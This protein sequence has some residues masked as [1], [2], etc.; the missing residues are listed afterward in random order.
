MT[1]GILTSGTLTS[2][3]LMSGTLKFGHLREWNGKRK[4]VLLLAAPAFTSGSFALKSGSFTS[5]TFRGGEEIPQGTQLTACLQGRRVQALSSHL[6]SKFRSG[7][8]A[9]YGV[10]KACLWKRRW[11]A[12]FRYADIGHAQAGQRRSWSTSTG[13]C[14]KH[15]RADMKASSRSLLW[16]H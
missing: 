7:F 5:G 1:S 9:P 3:T 12:H 15:S 16:E 8:S 10:Q 11:K 2:G 13:G 6:S 14:T 4:M